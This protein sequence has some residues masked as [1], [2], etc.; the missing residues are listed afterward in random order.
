MTYFLGRD[1]H[2]AITTEHDICGLSVAT[3]SG[4]VY[5]DNVIIG[6]A[7]AINTTS[8]A[9]TTSAHGLATGDP[10]NVTMDATQ[11]VPGSAGSAVNDTGTRY[12]AIVV[13]ATNIKLAATYADALAD[14]EISFSNDTNVANMNITRELSAGATDPAP[15]LG[16]PYNFIKNRSHPKYG[17]AAD[18]GNYAAIYGDSTTATGIVTSGATKNTVPDLT[19]VEVSVNAM[20]EDIAFIGQRTALKAEIKNEVTVT[21]TKKQS[22]SRY[23]ALFQKARCGLLAYSDTN[24]TTVEVDSASVGSALPAQGEMEINNS[25]GTDSMPTQNYGY[26]VHVMMKT[27]GE[28]LTLRNASIQ[29]YS[30]TISADG[31]TEESI[32]FYGHVKPTVLNGAVGNITL[33]PAD[34]L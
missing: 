7:S 3:E 23:N 8:N 13:D 28:V 27:S 26:R 12:Y 21:L 2:V 11:T 34:D 9:I 4:E 5:V 16:T 29:S 1:V 22:D 30:T 32:E 25:L 18:V 33:T 24:K 14:T 6:A 31:V 17:A 19:G 10:V 15:D 20:D